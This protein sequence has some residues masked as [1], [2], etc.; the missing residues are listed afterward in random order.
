MALDAP[1][2]REQRDAARIEKETAAQVRRVRTRE[3]AKSH[4]ILDT[5]LVDEGNRVE[6]TRGEGPVI[7]GA[8]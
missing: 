5:C 6:V 3:P 7:Q 8:S 1:W 4:L 2:A